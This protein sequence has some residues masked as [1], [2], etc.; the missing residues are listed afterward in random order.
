MSLIF[1]TDLVKHMAFNRLPLWIWKVD[2]YLIDAGKDQPHPW[3]PR[4]LM[5]SVLCHLDQ[6]MPRVYYNE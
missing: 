4:A 6:G 1:W 3:C 5:N 2:M